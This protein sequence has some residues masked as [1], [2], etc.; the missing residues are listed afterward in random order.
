MN[1]EDH[2]LARSERQAAG[3]VLLLH[4]WW[5]L[6]PFF[7]GLC[8][9]LAESGFVALAPDLYHGQTAST[10]EEAKKLRS[11]VK[12]DA[13][14]RQIVDAA[15]HL[16]SLDAAEH[17]RTLCGQVQI[18]VVGFSLGGYWALWLADQEASPVAATVA[19]YASRNGDYTR[20]PSA[21]QFHLAETDPYTA[22]S[23]VKK[24]QK[25]LSAAGKQAEFYTYPGTTHWFMESD[26][27][28]A[29]QA[30]AATLA[31]TRT[32]AFLKAHLQS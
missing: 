12:Q 22:A 1:M 28:D 26:R 4:A 16:C 2:Y 14:A 10:I 25:S 29:Y 32:L 5:G 31:W 23:G 13:V 21:F 7:K 15:R 11:K 27:A 24:L 3:G 9:R 17:L 8:D 30:E 20:S 19:F 6:T 18:G